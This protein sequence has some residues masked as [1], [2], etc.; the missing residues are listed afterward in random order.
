MYPMYVRNPNPA[1]KNVTFKV[2]LNKNRFMQMQSLKIFNFDS[3][4]AL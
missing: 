1:H 3:S 2:T 4:A